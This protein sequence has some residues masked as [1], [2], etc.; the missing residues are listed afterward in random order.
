MD[1]TSLVLSSLTQFKN[2]F[3]NYNQAIIWK[4]LTC[5]LTTRRNYRNCK[6]NINN[7]LY[8]NGQVLNVMLYMLDDD[9]ELREY[10]FGKV[11]QHIKQGLIKN[12]NYGNE[13]NWYKIF[14]FF[15]V[16]RDNSTT[17]RFY[18]RIEY[19]LFNT[20]SDNTYYYVYE[21][22]NGRNIQE[23]I[24][25]PIIKNK[26]ITDFENSS[27]MKNQILFCSLDD[28]N[29]SDEIEKYMGPMCDFYNG[30]IPCRFI[31]GNQNTLTY[32]DLNFNEYQYTKHQNHNVYVKLF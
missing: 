5:L 20:L 30:R 21:Y 32:T 31:I 16:N 6:K 23:K 1:Y 13:I 3:I 19:K 11:N 26:V 27:E 12:L 18:L 25:F 15:G 4:S 22:D 10:D 28:D 7:C 14:K 8:P 2:Y 17:I 24:K 29:F 9:D